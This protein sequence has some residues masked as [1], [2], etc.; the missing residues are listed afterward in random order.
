[1][2]NQSE[3]NPSS[4]NRHQF[5]TIE[6]L[7]YATVRIRCETPNGESTGT[8][9]HFA[10]QVADGQF[11]PA[12]VTN[13]HVVEGAHTGNFHVHIDGDHSGSSAL[14][15]T[16]VKIHDFSSAVVPHPDPDIDLCVIPTTDLLDRGKKE[17]TEV[18][19]R[20]FQKGHLLTPSEMDEMQGLENIVMTGYPIGLWDQH[21]NMPVMRRGV[22]A[23]NPRLDYQGR[24]EFLID[25]AVFPGS[26][27]SPVVWKSEGFRQ[28]RLGGTVVGGRA[29]ALLGILYAGPLHEV[30]GVINFANIPT[31][32]QPGIVSSI[33]INLGAVIKADLLLDFEDVLKQKLQSQ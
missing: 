24:R 7:Q 21:N 23:T 29:V 31:Q 15:Y 5:S 8:G 14:P 28:K 27:G 26:S 16:A 19:F 32:A 30:D 3:A 6:Q 10:F 22:A 9:F 13:K 18:V 12:I 1:M 17:G 20:T 33:P 25:V 11:I 2:S 4:S